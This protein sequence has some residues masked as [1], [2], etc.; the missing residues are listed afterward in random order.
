LNITGRFSDA[1]CFF[2]KHVEI[3]QKVKKRM[4][5]QTR[6][7]LDYAFA[8]S[9]FGTR[10]YEKS[11]HYVTK[12]SDRAGQGSELYI[13]AR[14]L[15]IL[16]YY[17]TK[18]WAGMEY[19]T[20]SVYR[21][22]LRTERLFRTE[23]IFLAFIRHLPS[24]QSDGHLLDRF[25][26]LYSELNRLFIDRREADIEYYIHIRAWLKSK[27]DRTDFARCVKEQLGEDMNPGDQAH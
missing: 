23:K 25:S 24:V 3:F 11:L 2:W 9:C 26:E 10:N 22:L 17:E 21:H 20:R 7:N 19:A 4:T 12:V 18:N 27:I 5:W 13:F 16:I 1:V 8:Y 14:L 15:S 6:A